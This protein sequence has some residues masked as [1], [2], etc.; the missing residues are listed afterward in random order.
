MTAFFRV[1]HQFACRPAPIA[2]A[3][4]RFIQNVTSPTAQVVGRAANWPPATCAP[5]MPAACNTVFQLRLQLLAHPPALH[6]RCWCTGIIQHVSGGPQH[7][8]HLSWK[9][10]SVVAGQTERA[11]K[12]FARR[13]TSSCRVSGDRA[14]DLLRQGGI[15]WAKR[16][17]WR[18]GVGAA[19]VTACHACCPLHFF[20]PGSF[21]LYLFTSFCTGSGGGEG[22]A[23]ERL[24]CTMRLAAVCAQRR[25]R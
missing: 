4:I 16:G 17:P 13:V 2:L 1:A 11:G 3:M 8:H 9:E 19:G 21:S 14:S 20:R 22:R 18:P 23:Q 15:I 7:R 24:F 10:Y 12:T 25:A 6:R 5:C